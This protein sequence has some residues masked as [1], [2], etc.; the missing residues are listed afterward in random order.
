[1]TKPIKQPNHLDLKQD[2]ECFKEAI[3]GFKLSAKNIETNTASTA[4]TLKELHTDNNEHLKIIAGKKQVPLSIFIIIVTLLSGLII[5]TE[6]KYS[7]VAIDIGWDHIKVNTNK[8]KPTH[9]S[10]PNDAPRLLKV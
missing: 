4:A 10:L 9:I 5:A 6:V 2:H 8:Y 1:M 3:D 7:G